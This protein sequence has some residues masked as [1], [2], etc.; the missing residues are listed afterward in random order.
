VLLKTTIGEQLHRIYKEQSDKP[1]VK[2]FS[3]DKSSLLICDLEIVKDFQKF[4]D[5]DIYMSKAK[6]YSV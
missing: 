4:T 5:I 2:I 3:F 1:Y 6:L